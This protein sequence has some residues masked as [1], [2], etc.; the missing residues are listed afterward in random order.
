MAASASPTH[1]HAL[2]GSSDRRTIRNVTLRFGAVYWIG[3]FVLS[4]IFWGVAGTDPIASALG[5]MVHYAMCAL[6]AAAMSLILF[7][8]HEKLTQT[9][10]SEDALLLLMLASFAL[11]LIV[12]PL[13]AG[14]GYL[15]YVLFTWPYSVAFDLKDFGFDMAYGGGLLFGWACLFVAIMFAF[16]LNE[17]EQRLAAV[18]EE[19][20]QAQM[21]ALRYQVNPHFL[22]NTLNSVVGLVEEGET[23][24]AEHMLLSLSGFLRTTLALDPLHDVALAE[25][26]A[27]QKQ[28]LDIEGERFSDRMSFDM[29]IDPETHHALVPSLILQPLVEN[30]I[31]HGVAATRGRVAIALSA[32][33]EANRLLI[34]IENDM[35]PQQESPS[36]STGMGVGLANVGARVQARFATD[37]TVTSGAVDDNRFRVSLELPWRRA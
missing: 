20:L 3:V 19:A 23:A 34:S 7:R 37:G 22:F 2:F 32:R 21:R 36:T 9:R 11:S 14:L 30:A 26:I 35:P 13:W 27:L 25:E 8:L 31:K 24:Q 29:S 33:R 5:K 28:Y 4:S 16:E 12:A 17:R 1:R 10:T 15:V 18:R 6:V